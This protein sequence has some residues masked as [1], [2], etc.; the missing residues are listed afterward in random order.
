MKE[1]QDKNTKHDGSGDQPMA[2]DEDNKVANIQSVREN[3]VVNDHEMI[4]VK[5]EM[6]QSN[7]G[8][9]EQDDNVDAK[10]Q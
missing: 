10:V 3:D 1:E 8:N 5:K 7:T 2:V 9:N 4:C 6:P